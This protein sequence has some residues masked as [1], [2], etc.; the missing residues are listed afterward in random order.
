MESS[1]VRRRRTRLPELR[2]PW[3]EGR[4]CRCS[5]CSIFLCRCCRR[6]CCCCLCWRRCCWRCCGLLLLLDTGNDRLYTACC[7]AC[8]RNWLQLLWLLLWLLLLWRLL[9]HMGILLL[10]LCG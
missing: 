5:C 2:L 4:I 10:L 8:Y 7:R 6:S 3:L 9:L 1:W